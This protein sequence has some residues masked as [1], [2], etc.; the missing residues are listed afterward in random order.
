LNTQISSLYTWLQPQLIRTRIR[1]YLVKLCDF[2]GDGV[3]QLEMPRIQNSVNLW[4]PTV[5][6]TLTLASLV[7]NME[8]RLDTRSRAQQVPKFI[9][10]EGWTLSQRYLTCT[11]LIR[12]GYSGVLWFPMATQ[13]SWTLDP[14]Y[15][16]DVGR[17][18]TTTQKLIA[19]LLNFQLPSELQTPR[20]QPSYP[21]CQTHQTYQA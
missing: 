7:R 2:K 17:S 10:G 16:G 13:S 5:T 6:P 4:T 9:A 15:H 11:R 18:S 19:T 8:Y 3:Y 14:E 20:N 21:Q 12:G 1:P